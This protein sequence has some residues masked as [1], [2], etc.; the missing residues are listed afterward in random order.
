MTTKTIILSI[1][2]MGTAFILSGLF[3]RA[4]FKATDNEKLK[5]SIAL[6]LGYQLL[7]LVVSYM[8]LFAAISALQYILEM[9]LSIRTV[10]IFSALLL[11]PGVLTVYLFECA[12]GVRKVAFLEKLLGNLYPVEYPD[13]DEQDEDDKV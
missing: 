12:F 2:F 5:S 1:V 3:K 7:Y 11:L 4:Q 9:P 6:R 8:A 13:P 10:A